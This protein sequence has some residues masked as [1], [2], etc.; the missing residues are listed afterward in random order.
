MENIREKIIKYMYLAIDQEWEDIE[1]KRPDEKID[2]HSDEVNPTYD[3]FM[4]N[5]E[6][7]IIEHRF[8][9]VEYED[10]IDEI[11]E[12]Y[13][14]DYKVRWNMLWEIKNHIDDLG[15]KID[16]WDFE[17]YKNYKQLS[18]MYAYGVA[19]NYELKEEVCGNCFHG[20]INDL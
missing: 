4:E 17:K 1:P 8:N 7:Y 5:I 9:S 3:E 11:M 18:R 6:T 13:K 10:E 16:D 12:D 20:W 15:V 14:N 19:N 2:L